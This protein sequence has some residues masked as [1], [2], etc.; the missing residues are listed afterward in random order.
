MQ[1]NANTDSD[2]RL[3]RSATGRTVACHV[4]IGRRLLVFAI[5]IPKTAV[6]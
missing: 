3:R 6:R 2:E 1:E 4:D 5:N